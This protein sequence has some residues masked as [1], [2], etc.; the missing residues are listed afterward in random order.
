MA[1]ATC[2]Y[3]GQPIG[4]DVRFYKGHTLAHAACEEEAQ[5]AR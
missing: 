2:V 1:E 5:A 3:C 4:Y